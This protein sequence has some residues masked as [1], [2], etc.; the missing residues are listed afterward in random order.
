[1]TIGT[2]FIIEARK[3]LRRNVEKIVHCLEQL[4]DDDINF[5]PFAGANS[6]GNIVTHLCGNVGQWLIAGVGQRPDTRNRPAE[7]AQDLAVR[8]D[9]LIA[10]LKETHRVADETLAAIAEDQVLAPRRIQGYDETVL[11]A[12]FHAVSHFEGHTHQI[13]YITRMRLGERYQ[14]KWVPQTKEQV[15]GG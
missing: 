2:A 10:K 4:A 6:I 7:F 8:C 15:S 9:E 14:F 13:V 3:T 11:S 5:R 1:M 12:I